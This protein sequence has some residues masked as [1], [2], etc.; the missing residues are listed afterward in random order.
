ML[1][2]GFRQV[3]ASQKQFKYD[4]ILFQFE[5]SNICAII[6]FNSTLVL[7]FLSLSCFFFSM[8][9]GRRWGQWYS[10]CWWKGRAS[11]KPFKQTLL[12]GPSQPV[13]SLLSHNS[14]LGNWR[15]MFSRVWAKPKTYNCVS[16]LNQQGPY[17]W[18]PPPAPPPPPTPS[19]RAAWILF[20]K[21][22]TAW[23]KQISSSTE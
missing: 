18:E 10:W 1:C 11:C 21:L 12:S 2:F 20:G 13:F 16:F 17:K 7:F 19:I 4:D 6:I 5:R 23:S 14:F 9:A 3:E 22:R 8:S 15:I